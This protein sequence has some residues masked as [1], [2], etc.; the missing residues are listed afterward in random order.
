MELLAPAVA[1]AAQLD[2]VAR[3]QRDILDLALGQGL[4]RHV[5]VAEILVPQP[6]VDLD[7]VDQH[8]HLRDA[9]VL[10]VI[11][12]CEVV[13]PF[14]AGEYIP[15]DILV[16]A[17]R[18]DDRLAGGDGTG[19]GEE[20][21]DEN[22]VLGLDP[23]R[24]ARRRRRRR[25]WIVGRRRR[26]LSI[27]D[28]DL[29][30]LANR[31]IFEAVPVEVAQRCDGLAELRPRCGTRD[32]QAFPGGEV[33]EIQICGEGRGA[34]VDHIDGAGGVAARQVRER[35]A[36]EEIFA[37]VA[38]EV[39]GAT[40]VEAELILRPKPGD[41]KAVRSI[42][43]RE[44]QGRGK[45][46]GVA[47][48]D[49]GLAR[50]GAAVARGPRG[51]E[52]HVVDPVAVHISR[53]ADLLAESV[54]DAE[55]EHDEPILRADGSEIDARREAIVAT[56]HHIHGAGPIH[57]VRVGEIRTEPDIGEAVAVDVAETGHRLSGE[58]GDLGPVDSETVRPV[59]RSEIETLRQTFARPE[60]YIRA[61]GFPHSVRAGAVCVDDHIDETVAVDIAGG[62]D[63]PAR[64]VAISKSREDRRA[65]AEFVQRRTGNER[66]GAAIDQVDFSSVRKTAETDG[67]RADQEIHEPIIVEI[68][69]LGDGYARRVASAH[70]FEAHTGSRLD[71]L[72]IRHR[73]KARSST[74]ND[75]DF[76]HVLAPREVRGLCAN[77]QISPTVAIEI[78]YGGDCR[79]GEHVS[80]PDSIERREFDKD[81]K[82]KY[83]FRHVDN[84]N[85]SVCAT[86]LA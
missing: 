13:E 83:F 2:H 39:A 31:Q 46:R 79:T 5:V 54:L 15:R 25:R 62:V 69:G 40:D 82:V 74:V 59:E 51:A 21:L 35:R 72:D 41:A 48:H 84:L 32:H 24:V 60:H 18:R 66:L 85:Q 50:P 47:E 63:A 7:A 77:D 19:G 12:E 33:R 6:V 1:E 29:A 44:V 17:E 55:P 76:A 14:G 38:I 37:S 81:R 70:A 71:C 3:A 65:V 42:Q 56:E 68:A 78:A 34:A 64:I 45:T 61:A 58:V 4:G 75:I 27:D 10:V 9:V 86:T 22:H 11:A 80:S 36:D 67:F 30:R 57:A 43:S 28:V 73:R 53:R 26:R 16:I 23:E 8:P 52:N 20:A 49:I